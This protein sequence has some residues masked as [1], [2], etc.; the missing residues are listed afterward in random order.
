MGGNSTDQT[1][2]AMYLLTVIAAI[3]LPLSFVTGLLGINV[4]GIPGTD[5]PWAFAAVAVV[6]LCLGVIEYWVLRILKWI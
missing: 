1:N 5:T 6:I 3:F 4:G 2:R